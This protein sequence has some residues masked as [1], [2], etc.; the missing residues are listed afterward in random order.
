MTGSKKRQNKS[1]KIL[2]Q[3]QI[4]NNQYIAILKLVNVFTQVSLYPTAPTQVQ[5]QG[6]WRNLSFAAGTK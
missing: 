2:K 6:G 1:L 5:G 3:P 4:L